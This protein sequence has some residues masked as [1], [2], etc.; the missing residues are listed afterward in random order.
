MG[1]TLKFS[2]SFHPQTDGQSEEANSTVLDLLKCYVS[3]HKATWEHYLPLVEYAYNNT[4]HTSTGKAPFE[5]VEGGKKV[6]P[7][8]HTKDKIFE[9][10][11]YVQNT[12]EAYKKIKLALEKTQ[13][14]QKKAAD[15]Q[16]RELVFS[17]GDWVL[18]RFEK[19]RLRK[20]KGKERLFPK[21]G[22]RY[23]G[24]FQ[25]R[26]AFQQRYFE[27]LEFFDAPSG[28]VFLKI[29]G[30]ST[31]GG[32]TN[33]YSAVLAKKFKAALVSLEHRYYGESAPFTNLTT[34]NLKYLTTNQALFD[35][36]SFRDY[37]Q[38]LLRT[39]FNLP[40]LENPWIVF[41]VSY[42]GAL[43][44]WFQLKFPH[45]SCGSLASS[46]V[47]EAIFNYTA[48]DEQVATSAGPACSKVLMEITALVEEG[49]VQ[50]ATAVKSL[51]GAEQLAIDGD[52]M[53][54]LADAAAIAF[55]YGNPDVLCNSIV[56]ENLHDQD[57]LPYG[58]QMHWEQSLTAWKSCEGPKENIFVHKHLV[59]MSVLQA[60]PLQPTT[61]VRPNAGFNGQET[62]L[63]AMNQNMVSN[64]MYANI[65]MQPGFE[66]TQGLFG[67]SQ[68]NLSM[69]GFSIPLVKM[70]PRHQ[71]VIGQGVQMA[72][73]GVPIMQT[74][75]FDN[76]E[77]MDKPKLYKEGG[78]SVQYD[79]FSG[80]DK[81]IKAFFFLEQFEKAFARRNFTKASK[82]SKAAS[83]LKGN[84]RADA[85]LRWPKV[86][87]VSIATHNDLSSMID[88]YAIDPDFKDVISAIALGKKEEPFTLQ[89]GYLLHGNRLCIT[90]SLCEKVMSDAPG[91]PWKVY[92]VA[93][94]PQPRWFA[95]T[96]IEYIRCDVLNEADTQEK[97][98]PL[99]V[100]THL[101]WWFGKGKRDGKVNPGRWGCEEVYAEYVKEYYIKTFGVSV[102]TYNQEHL[103]ETQVGDSGDRQWWYQVCTELAYF[104]V[105]PENNSI[106]S[107]LVDSKYHLDL[108]SNVFDK[109][110]YPEVDITNM[111]YGGKGIAGSKIFF[112]NGSQDPW[113]HAS[114]QISSRGE[115]TWLITCHNCGHGTD[116]RGCP[117]SPLQLEGDA[118]KCTDPDAVYKARQAITK[119]IEACL[120]ENVCGE[121]SLC[122]V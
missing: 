99:R 47:V 49:L 69:A 59:R 93:R 6:P 118:S 14:K 100:V 80:F 25:N 91:G 40:D 87:A 88:E 110:M 26:H 112:T 109:G 85:L 114:K 18:L 51:F 102:D 27:Y 29:C 21:L 24:P 66:G 101:F 83:F 116:L 12:D 106:R 115:P 117:Q 33:D 96:P 89:D 75:P 122:K 121:S 5:I 15:R 81:G 70:T 57:L 34:K 20:M 92:G 53:Y 16:R 30:E 82:V 45:L 56:A 46:G 31:C 42:S 65:G 43:S 68:G 38:G 62:V 119:H 2:S 98:T 86:N 73:T 84:A 103:K 39:R 79:T 61:L 41:G 8:L 11:K 107:H 111:Y 54:F 104:Q 67:V 120:A 95:D 17:L 74:V 76:L 10:D 60:I 19:A 113:R 78:Q 71:H 35:L 97:I 23:Y 1:T 4:V 108:C 48:F 77:S 72:P 58:R 7:I 3:E 105:A 55:Q 13:S 50:N 44:A 63:Q 32:I 64:P 90:H 28:P 9:A 36:A 37:Y 22:M 52:F 94:R